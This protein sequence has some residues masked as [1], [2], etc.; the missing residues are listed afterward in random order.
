M[1][2]FLLP[3]ANYE[4]ELL[5]SSNTQGQPSHLLRNLEEMAAAV[6]LSGGCWLIS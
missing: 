5:L 3:G 2:T 4:T 6:H 1:A